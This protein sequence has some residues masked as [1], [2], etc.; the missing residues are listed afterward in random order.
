MEFVFA[1]RALGENSIRK[2]LMS[3]GGREERFVWKLSMFSRKL[4]HR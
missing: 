1:A 3:A 4:A 2:G